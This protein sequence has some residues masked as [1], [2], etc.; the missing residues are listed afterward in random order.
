[1]RYERLEV[2]VEI[3]GRPDLSGPVAEV[4][5]D[6]QLLESTYPGCYIKW[7][8]GEDSYFY[9][10]LETDEEYAERMLRL[11]AKEA[12]KLTRKRAQYE[13]LKKDL[14]LDDEQ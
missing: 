4:I 8:Y 7:F 12:A 10:R 6:L 1:M 11:Q 5:Q 14:G 2:E 13:K 3:Q 9:K